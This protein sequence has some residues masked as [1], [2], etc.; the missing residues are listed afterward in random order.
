MVSYQEKTRRGRSRLPVVGLCGLIALGVSHAGCGGGAETPGEATLSED[1]ARNNLSVEKLELIPSEIYVRLGDTFWVDLRP[2]N[3]EGKVIDDPYLEFDWDY[4]AGQVWLAAGEREPGAWISVQGRSPGRSDAFWTME[5]ISV[6]GSGKQ[7]KLLLHV[8]DG[9]ASTVERDWIQVDLPS[10]PGQ[11][12]RTRPAALL[13]D[14][15]VDGT[16][17]Q[18]MVFSV[19]GGGFLEENLTDGCHE[20]DAFAGNARANL[21]WAGTPPPGVSTSPWSPLRGDRVRLESGGPA[22]VEMAF[23]EFVGEND[24]PVVWG[25]I[26]DD[27]QVTQAI[28]DE[29][30]AGIEFRA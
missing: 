6:A 10:P 21:G 16:C 3:W 30:R 5:N 8:S 9:A 28:F 17:K 29:A 23:Q 22:V 7:A 25:R 14:A 12:A 24:D 4:P 26:R 20:I 13:I 27:I 11:T 15:V 19:A 2:L 1:G 18:D